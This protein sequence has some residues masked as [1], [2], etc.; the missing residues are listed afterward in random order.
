MMPRLTHDHQVVK[1]AC[2]RSLRP[3]GVLPEFL[4]RPWLGRTLSGRTERARGVGGT[5]SSTKPCESARFRR[6]SGRLNRL[7]GEPSCGFTKSLR[8]LFGG[9]RKE[10]GNGTRERSARDQGRDRSRQAERQTSSPASPKGCRCAFRRC[11]RRRALSP[12]VKRGGAP[13][14]L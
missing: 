13:G 12:A 4:T 1:D 3:S 14:R 6:R 7:R 9:S 8:C 2:A 11:R 5:D 10:R